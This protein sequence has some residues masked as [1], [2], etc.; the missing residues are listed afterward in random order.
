MQLREAA[1]SAAAIG[2]HAASLQIALDA[3]QAATEAMQA[4]AEQ[5][6]FKLEAAD[7]RL[8]SLHDEQEAQLQLNCEA[9]KRWDKYL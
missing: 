2:E 9:A 5:L 1:A 7:V 4:A 8:Q 6:R 3:S